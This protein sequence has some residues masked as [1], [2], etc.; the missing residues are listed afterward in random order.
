MSK[1]TLGDKVR[2]SSR[3]TEK[4][5][6]VVAVVPANTDASACLP[7]GFSCGSSSGFG[8][9][10]NHES[11]LVKVDGKGRGLYWPRVKHLKSE[12]SK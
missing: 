6:S 7:D 3:K 5:G 2:W 1:V 12:V 4:V 11:Y 10:R 9:S 8:M